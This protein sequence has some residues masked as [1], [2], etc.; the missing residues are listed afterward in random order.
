MSAQN[1]YTNLFFLL[2]PY[3]TINTHSFFFI[4]THTHIHTKSYEKVLWLVKVKKEKVNQDTKFDH[5]KYSFLWHDQNWRITSTAY[6]DVA[7]LCP[8]SCVFHD[9]TTSQEVSLV[10]LL[11][12]SLH[13][14]FLLVFLPYVLLSFSDAT[15]LLYD[16]TF[17]SSNPEVISQLYRISHF[18]SHTSSYLVCRHHLPNAQLC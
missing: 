5:Q 9:T 12:C 17:T 11:S 8:D 10:T 4:H 3:F 16:L 15:A 18:L 14:P 2:Q 7:V 6:S 1:S 13:F